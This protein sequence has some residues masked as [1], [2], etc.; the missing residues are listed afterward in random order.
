[1]PNS[2]KMDDVL[3]YLL[4]LHNF[5]QNSEN[6][7]LLMP[8]RSRRLRAKLVG[9]SVRQH[10]EA[11]RVASAVRDPNNWPKGARLVQRGIGGEMAPRRTRTPSEQLECSAD[12][13]SPDAPRRHHLLQQDRRIL[14]KVL[15]GPPKRSD[16]AMRL[17]NLAFLAAAVDHRTSSTW[18]LISL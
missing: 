16:G 15:R 18:S 17:F 5:C 9:V 10:R 11:F 8:E 7:S 3:G 6:A 13:Q 1:M 14:K 4:R 2:D 12:R